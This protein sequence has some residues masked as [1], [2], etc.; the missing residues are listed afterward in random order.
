MLDY[1]LNNDEKQEFILYYTR[2]G[3]KLLVHYAN[4]VTKE[5]FHTFNNEYEILKKMEDQVK[6]Y[7]AFF[8]QYY[9]NMDKNSI[10]ISSSV[11]P[12]CS[13]SS[14]CIYDEKILSIP[15]YTLITIGAIGLIKKGMDYNKIKKIQKDYEKHKIYIDNKKLIS[16]YMMKD[17]RPLNGYPSNIIKEAQSNIDNEVN[18]I[19]VNTVRLLK[20]EQ[21]ESLVNG[22]VKRENEDKVYK[23]RK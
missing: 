16:T 22:A 21:L 23:L 12:V 10:F 9:E 3:N 5:I 2:K 17:L 18:T 13:V 19:T 4:G 20:K 7:D 8:M 14:I 15:I 11:L 1:S 6:E